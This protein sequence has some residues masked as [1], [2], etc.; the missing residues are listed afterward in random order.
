MA[1]KVKGV[2]DATVDADICV[3]SGVE[4]SLFAPGNILAAWHYYEHGKGYEL[5]MLGCSE[6][7]EEDRTE[8][9]RP[10][11]ARRLPVTI[12]TIP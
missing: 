7:L 10:L 6:V 4:I 12:A 5:S 11:I 8:D 3:M 9:T 2:V 1:I